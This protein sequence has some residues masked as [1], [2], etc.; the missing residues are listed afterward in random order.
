MG[1][2]TPLARRLSTLSWTVSVSWL[3]NV[4]DYKDSFSSIP[5]VE[6]LDLDSP[7]Y[8]WSVFLLI[9]ERNPS[10]SSPSTPL[11]RCPPLLLNLTMQSS[12]PTPPWNTLTALLWSTTRPSMTSAVE[13]WT[14]TDHHTLTSTD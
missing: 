10:S 7:L 1:V 14:L 12:P 8:S 4:L 9:T 5:S 2:T 11:P 3:I 13:I 6:E